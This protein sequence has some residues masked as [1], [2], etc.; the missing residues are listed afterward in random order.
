MST[1]SGYECFDRRDEELKHLHRLVRDLE[2]EAR[3]RRRRRNHEEHAEGS[4]SVRS[5]HEEASHLSGS[6]RYKERSRE[7]ADRDSTSSEGRR[8]R[9]VAMDAVSRVLRRATWSPFLEEIERAPMLSRFSWA[10]F[11]SYD[12]KT[13]PIEHV[14]HYI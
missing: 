1:T 10:L 12:R 7:Y 6:H 14:S 2:L 4:A 3:G 13:D 11:N 9:N 5:S 8:P